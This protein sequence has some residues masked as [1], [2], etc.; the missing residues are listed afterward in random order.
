M[1][2]NR[3]VVS[4]DVDGKNTVRVADISGNAESFQAVVLTMPVPQILQLRGSIQ[5]ALGT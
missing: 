3:Q 2:Y 1:E 4:V 5:K